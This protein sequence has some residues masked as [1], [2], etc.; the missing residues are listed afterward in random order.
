MPGST[1]AMFHRAMRTDAQRMSPHLFRMLFA[2]LILGS[3]VIA[4]I[5]SLSLGAP[6]LFFFSNILWLNFAL[7]VLAA[8]SFL[9]T[10]ITEE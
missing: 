1:T 6:G 2:G 8:V 4:H 5:R 10:A 3:L 9:A 7:I